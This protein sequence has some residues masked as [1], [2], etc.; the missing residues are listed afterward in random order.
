MHSWRMQVESWEM[1]ELLTSWGELMA[2][3][4]GGKLVMMVIVI[5]IMGDDN[6]KLVLG[7]NRKPLIVFLLRR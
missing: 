5:M 3:R 7:G 2:W 4:G 1:L 6:I